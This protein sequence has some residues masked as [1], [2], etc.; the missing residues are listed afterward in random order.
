LCSP[1][2]LFCEDP[3]FLPGFSGFTLNL[4]LQLEMSPFL[5]VVPFFFAGRF[6][7]S[8][9]GLF[10]VYVA[11]PPPFHVIGVSRKSLLFTEHIVL[12]WFFFTLV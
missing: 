1:C 8:F 6:F 9:Y 11:N 5:G 10:F 2:P 3:P 7:F 4:L 12:L